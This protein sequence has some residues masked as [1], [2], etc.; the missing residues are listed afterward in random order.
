MIQG[1]GSGQVS[2]APL[3]Q[4]CTRTCSFPVLMGQRIDIFPLAD[5][6]SVFDSLD[7]PGDMDN[8]IEGC[9]ALVNGDRT[10]TITF[11]PE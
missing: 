10:I 4:V 1:G 11:E 9:S 8:G 2:L 7:Q 3:G 6:G 5:D